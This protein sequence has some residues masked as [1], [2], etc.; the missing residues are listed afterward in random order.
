MKKL[1][2]II[3]IILMILTLLSILY[4]LLNLYHYLGDILYYGSAVWCT[5]IETTQTGTLS[6]IMLLVTISFYLITSEGMKTKWK[7]IMVILVTLTLFSL[8][9]TFFI[10]LYYTYHKK[11]GFNYAVALGTSTLSAVMILI[12]IITYIK[13]RKTQSSP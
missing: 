3:L 10:F 13:T 5:F 11:V 12:T 2:K 6:A 4:T 1:W 8:L 7:V 9:A